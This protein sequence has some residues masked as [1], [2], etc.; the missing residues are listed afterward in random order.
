MA[1]NGWWP[2][3]GVVAKRPADDSGDGLMYCRSSVWVDLSSQF[4]MTA[5]LSS[6]YG[7]AKLFEG[8]VPM[9]SAT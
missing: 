6:M 2:D 8:P 1:N 5:C 9:Y 4:G 7:T 3:A